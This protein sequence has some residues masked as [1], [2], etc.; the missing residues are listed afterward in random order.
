MFIIDSRFENDLVDLANEIIEDRMFEAQD[1]SEI[2][3]QTDA[4]TA[5]VT[6]HIEERNG[7]CFLVETTTYVTEFLGETKVPAFIH[8]LT[9]NIQV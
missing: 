1:W 8:N 9:Q 5:D 3:P 4:R 2:N 7:E 6:F